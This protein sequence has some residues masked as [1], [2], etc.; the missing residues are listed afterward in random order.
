[1][2]HF[3]LA[4]RYFHELSQPDVTKLEATLIARLGH[5]QELRVALGGPQG[6]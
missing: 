6:G 1:L 3:T 2:F 5:V 4:M